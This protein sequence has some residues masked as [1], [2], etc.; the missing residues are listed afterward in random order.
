MLRSRVH[1][2]TILLLQVEK[3]RSRRKQW[4]KFQLSLTIAEVWPG[5]NGETAKATAGEANQW[6]SCPDPC[7]HLSHQINKQKPM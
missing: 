4:E 2:C 6:V 5:M 3:Q 1:A 7:G